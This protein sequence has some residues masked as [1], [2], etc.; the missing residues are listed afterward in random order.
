MI[1]NQPAYN[2]T[3]RQR[4]QVFFSK[5]LKYFSENHYILGC[6]SGRTHTRRRSSSPAMRGP[7]A[8][9]RHEDS[10]RE[11]QYATF[12]D[13]AAQD[14]ER[15][16]GDSPQRY[17]ATGPARRVSRFRGRPIFPPAFTQPQSLSPRCRQVEG[18]EGRD[19]TLLPHLPRA[20][21]QRTPHQRHGIHTLSAHEG[22]L[23]RQADKSSDG[24]GRL[25]VH[26]P[27]PPASQDFCGGRH[28]RRLRPPHPGYRI[29]FIFLSATSSCIANTSAYPVSF[30]QQKNPPMLC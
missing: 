1:F 25:C 27:S 5:I 8:E 2:S 6:A 10:G 19:G 12:A 26:H 14:E 17:H 22:R 21:A 18:T 4:M 23:F 13:R 3:T 11:C 30:C 15:L 7:A 29:G 9:K 28:P 20:N 24:K 16:L